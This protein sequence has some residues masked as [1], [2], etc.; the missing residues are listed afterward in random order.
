M[1][2]LRYVLGNTEIV[3]ITFSKSDDSLF[4]LFFMETVGLGSCRVVRATCLLE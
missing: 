1:V 3:F 4:S 2:V